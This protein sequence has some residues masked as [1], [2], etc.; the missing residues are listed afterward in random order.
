MSL[1]FFV[2]DVRFSGFSIGLPVFRSTPVA[3]LT[4]TNGS[5]IEQF[6][7]GPVQRVGKAIAVEVHQDLPH[8]PVDVEIDQ[9]VL[10]DAVI[11]PGIVRGL[12]VGP[13]RFPRI[14]VPREDRHRPLVVARP[15]VGIPGSGVAGAVVEEV[16][17]GIVAVPAPGR[18][19]ASSS[20]HRLSRFP[21][22]LGTRLLPPGPVLYMRQICLPVFTSLAVTNPR[23]PNSPPLMPEITLSL[24]TIG[25]EVMV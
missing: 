1:V 18:A 21:P 10:V 14:G 13:L 3:Q 15:L 19:A 8:L 12:L 11:V 5:A 2:A 9:D 22:N 16:E 7:G 6:A 20:T 17:L 23:T 24:I 25:A 4:L